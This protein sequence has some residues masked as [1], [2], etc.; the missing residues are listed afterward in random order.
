MT[1]QNSFCG[2]N[3]YCCVLIKISL[4]F[5][6]KGSINSKPTVFQNVVWHQLK[7]V[8]SHNLKQ[9]WPRSLMHIYTC[10][11]LFLFWQHWARGLLKELPIFCF[12]F[13]FLELSI[14]WLSVEYYTHIWHV[15]LQLD[16]KMPVKHGCHSMDSTY[17]L[18]RTNPDSKVYGANMGPTGPRW[19]PCWAH[20]PFY[21]G[22]NPQQ[23][24]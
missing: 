17:T 4:K 8:A 5:V 15:L 10:S 19:A 13:H 21:L 24:N 9:Q 6:A 16:C 11:L 7:H 12:L 20:D 1:F 23:R 18:T 2:I 3:F 22:N 14:H